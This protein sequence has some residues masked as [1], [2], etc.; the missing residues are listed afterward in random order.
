MSHDGGISRR[1][2][3]W[4]LSA[5]AGAAMI[6]CRSANRRKTPEQSVELMND[7]A[8][9]LLNT[10][11]AL[12]GIISAKVIAANAFGGRDD[13]E[14]RL[15]AGR[16]YYE[17]VERI[18]S[19]H[20][21]DAENTSTRYSPANMRR[22]L[23]APLPVE[24]FERQY[25][26]GLLRD[27]RARMNDDPVFA[28]RINDYSGNVMSRLRCNC[29]INGESAACWKCVIVIVIIIIIIIV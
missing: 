7:E 26:D 25:F 17:A 8:E 6:A 21:A 23:A 4:M 3:V 28:R 29:E 1:H 20:D 5:S 2:A 19:S 10:E 22:V 14:N 18:G 9:R 15:L 12:P 11:P 13:E 27:T 24:R 16:L